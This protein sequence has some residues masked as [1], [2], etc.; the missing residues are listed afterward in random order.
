MAR[1]SKWQNT[2]TSTLKV[3]PF[4]LEKPAQWIELVLG[5]C[6]LVKVRW[7]RTKPKIN[8]HGTFRMI[9]A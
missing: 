8:M 3:N 6:T 4:Y 2:M 7:V 1:F 9:S 5:N